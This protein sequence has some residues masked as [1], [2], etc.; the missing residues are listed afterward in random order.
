M[1]PP[2]VFYNYTKLLVKFTNPVTKQCKDQK[3]NLKKW[4]F[5][6]FDQSSG[7]RAE[8]IDKDRGVIL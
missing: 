7:L 8:G 6:F 2:G 4:L 5:L 3:N 1:C